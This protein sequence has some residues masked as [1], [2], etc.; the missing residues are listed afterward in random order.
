MAPLHHHLELGGMPE[1][2]IVALYYTI[3][4]LACLTALLG[5]VQ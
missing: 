2:R 1:T 3:T 4:A 5:F